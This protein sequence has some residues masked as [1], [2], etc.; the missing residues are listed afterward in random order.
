MKHIKLSRGKSAIVDDMDF[1]S[2][3]AFKWSLTVGKTGKMYAH[4]RAGKPKKRLISMHRV[5]MGIDDKPGTV[6]VDHLNG[7]GLDNRRENLRVCTLGENSRNLH[8]AW[9][10]YGL[11]GVRQE[12]NGKWRARIRHNY[13]LFDVGTFD[14]ERDAAVAY[15]FASKLFHG[16]FGS[17]PG[18]EK[19]NHVAAPV[20]RR[21][22]SPLDNLA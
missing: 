21:I 10:K 11:R 13:K 1:E 14:T 18:H 19:Y 7:D 16:E 2:L 22:K 5:I 17:L 4:R 3:N 8:R 9:G 15:A 20:E 12:L 6:T